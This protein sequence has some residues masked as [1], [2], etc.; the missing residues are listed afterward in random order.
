MSVQIVLEYANIR[1]ELPQSLASGEF[2]GGINRPPR[3]VGSRN[4]QPL[5]NDSILDSVNDDSGPVVRIGRTAT[6]E[7]QQSLI[8]RLCGYGVRQ[9]L[10]QTV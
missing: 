8:W 9:Q 1:M 7:E 3:W 4:T 6:L 2:S 5:V 10:A